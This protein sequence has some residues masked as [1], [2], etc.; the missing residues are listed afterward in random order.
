LH[1]DSG[2]L[3]MPWKGIPSGHAKQPVVRRDG[4]FLPGMIH[5]RGANKNSRGEIGKRYIG[6]SLV[7]G[8]APYQGCL[9]SKELRGNMLVPGALSRG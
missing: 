2:L 7:W 9:S 1:A 5:R 3:R 6:G 4:Y 8:M